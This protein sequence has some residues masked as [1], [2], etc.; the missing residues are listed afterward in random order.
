MKAIYILLITVI[1]VGCGPSAEQITATAEV[2][3]AQTQTAAPTS[4]PTLTPTIT[5]TATP[6]Y[7]PTPEFSEV[8]ESESLGVSVRY[9]TGW[10]V[11]EN[12]IEISFEQDDKKI[13]VIFFPADVQDQYNGNPVA[14]L[15]SFILFS[16]IAM[17]DEERLHLTSLNDSQYALGVYSNPGE[18]LGFNNPSPLFAAMQFTDDFTIYME[19]YAP[20]GDED[21]DRQIFEM[22]LASL[23]P[24][25]PVNLVAAP[26][27]EP[28]VT[29]SLPELPEG[30]NWQGVEAI[31][32]A[33]PIPEGWYVTFTRSFESYQ[34]GLQ[35][36]DYQYLITQENP[37]LVGS[38]SPY[39]GTLTI[40]TFKKNDVNAVDA[41]N[42]FSSNLE[43]NPAVTIVDKQYSGQG[44]IVSYLY[45][46]NGINSDVDRD[47]PNYNRTARFIV[48]ANK[49]TNTFYLLNFE[50]A[51]EAWD[52][53][54]ETG[55][56]MMDALLELLGGQP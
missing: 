18:A 47:D 39:I 43:A 27:L 12:E 24:S 56:V 55:Q 48:L 17:P 44:N 19:M 9:P 42:E 6:A 54:W 33:L 10:E 53:E 2:A 14:A 21:G 36:Y 51:S 49:E 31:D 25:I 22:V 15:E 41:A 32:L 37:D 3:K 11:S 38:F 28:N 8:Y 26:T 30:Y 50:S 13:A 45:F 40:W 52:Q 34:G 16:G 35:E 23:P 29:A 46:I 7:T 4:T 20:A 1:L 5:P